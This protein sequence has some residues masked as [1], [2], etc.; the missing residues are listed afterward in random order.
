MPKLL[1]IHNHSLKLVNLKLLDL[2]VAKK[3]PSLY[4]Y[5]KYYSVLIGTETFIV[6]TAQS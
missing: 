5:L 4:D 3:I 2:Q 1:E 6:F